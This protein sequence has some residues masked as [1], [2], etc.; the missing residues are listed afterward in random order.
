MQYA[1]WLYQNTSGEDD[2]DEWLDTEELVSS[3]ALDS[4]EE[5]FMNGANDA[6]V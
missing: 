5:G 3:D 4:W 1:Y 2:R 6:V